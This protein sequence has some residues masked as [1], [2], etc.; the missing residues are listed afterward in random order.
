MPSHRLTLGV[1]RCLQWLWVGLRVSPDSASPTFPTGGGEGRARPPR[2][3]RCLGRPRTRPFG[4]PRP[5]VPAPLSPPRCPRPAVPGPARGGRRSAPGGGSG[6]DGSG[7]AGDGGARS[8]RYWRGRGRCPCVPARVRVR[9][10]VR[11]Y[12]FVHTCVCARECG[13]PFPRVCRDVR[14]A[15]AGC[16]FSCPPVGAA[17]PRRPPGR[18]REG[19]GSLPPAP[20]ASAPRRSPGLRGAR[21]QCGSGAES[22]LSRSVLSRPGAP[23]DPSRQPGSRR[24]SRSSARGNLP[25]SGKAEQRGASPETAPV[26]AGCPPRVGKE[27]RTGDPPP[28]RSREERS[29]GRSAGN[30]SFPAALGAAAAVSAAAIPAG[31]SAGLSLGAAPEHP[32]GTAAPSRPVPRVHGDTQEGPPTPGERFLALLF[33]GDGERQLFFYI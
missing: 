28:R 9:V 24:C 15:A 20:G 21:R 33:Q 7:A 10:R 30:V 22:S 14:G 13:C 17:V 31:P 18:M 32:A 11:V 19:L 5:S 3:G 1:P 26:R 16:R 2:A 27:E 25:R 4:C 8:R 23:L 29:A 6:A 12:M